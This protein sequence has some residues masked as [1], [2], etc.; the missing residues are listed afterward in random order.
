MCQ[1]P[2]AAQVL[3]TVVRAAGPWHFMIVHD[4]LAWCA[5]CGLNATMAAHHTKL[6]QP[7]RGVVTRTQR[8]RY[9]HLLRGDRPEAL[10]AGEDVPHL[11][12]AR[13]IVGWTTG[14]AGGGQA[15]ARR[16]EAAVSMEFDYDA[17]TFPTA[18]RSPPAEV[19]VAQAGTR[20]STAALGWLRLLES[21]CVQFCGR[22]TAYQDPVPKRHVPGRGRLRGPR[23]LT[24]AQRAAA[25]PGAEAPVGDSEAGGF[26]YQPGGAVRATGAAS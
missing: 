24:P 25:R 15:S 11:A 23:Q 22:P 13:R 2:G 5:R 7:C 20:H 16:A 17:A 4:D 18:G 8:P 10:V 1:D 21:F 6:G 12:G 26:V 14:P 9:N 3:E 19:A